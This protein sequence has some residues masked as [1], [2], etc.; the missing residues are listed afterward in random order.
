AD[1]R[2]HPLSPHRDEPA[3]LIVRGA[4]SVGGVRQKARIERAFFISAAMNAWRDCARCVQTS[5]R[6]SRWIS[7]GS[8]M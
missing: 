5:T 8:S 3:A 1:R 6:L 4:G 7:S 2:E